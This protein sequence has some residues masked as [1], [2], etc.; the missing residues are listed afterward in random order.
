MTLAA[1]IVA[2]REMLELAS[3]LAP[4]FV[5][6]CERATDRDPGCR[7]KI[8]I[9]RALRALDAWEDEVF[10]R[11]ISLVQQEPV[12]GG[13]EDTAAELRAECATKRYFYRFIADA[14]GKPISVV[15]PYDGT[16]WTLGSP[17]SEPKGPDRKEWSGYVGSYVR[18]RFSV[19]ERL[20]NVS[21]KN[22]GLHF[23][24]DG[25]RISGC[26]STP[27]ASSSLPTARPSTC[28]VP[29][30][31]SGTSG[32]TRPAADPRGV[33]SRALSSRVSLSATEVEHPRSRVPVRWPA[34]DSPSSTSSAA[35]PLHAGSGLALDAGV[36]ALREVAPDQR[37]A[38]G[39]QAR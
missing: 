24:G 2:G 10:V 23:Q 26:R 18:K 36:G 17:A 16:V 21:V 12:W 6:L 7:A 14:A 13:K 9:A 11:G 15:R 34:G 35:S 28:A 31:R 5:R 25:A 37:F 39:P 38:C 1:R 27:R 3:E 8:A 4:A 32:C 30:S 19:G 33:P 29:C 22:G 20:Y